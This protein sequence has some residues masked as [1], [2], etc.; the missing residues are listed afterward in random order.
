[1]APL[2]TSDEVRTYSVFASDSDTTPLPV[3]LLNF[4]AT[5]V[6]E[7]VQLRWVTASETHNDHFLVEQSTDG[8]TFN[9]VATVDGAGHSDTFLPYQVLDEQAHRGQNYYR[10][11]QVDFDGNV[12]RYP[13]TT[14]YFRAGSHPIEVTV[15]P[16]ENQLHIDLTESALVDQLALVMLR[17]IR[18]GYVWQET[19]VL[20]KHQ[21]I[22]LPDIFEEGV[23]IVSVLVSDI[24]LTRKVLWRY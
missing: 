14:T 18:G 2:S 13:I 24:Q 9:L 12:T 22:L 15:V 23:Y 19:V 1:M 21:S 10:L 16:E 17:D 8:I 20:D 4:T 6:A 7:G 11:T 5:P 3:E